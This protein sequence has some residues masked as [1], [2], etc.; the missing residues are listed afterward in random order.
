MKLT[1]IAKIKTASVLEEVK[2]KFYSLWPELL[3]VLKK[4]QVKDGM[5]PEIIKECLENRGY[6]WVWEEIYELQY[7]DYPVC[8][9]INYLE[10]DSE[11]ASQNE[12]LIFTLLLQREYLR[13]L[14]ETYLHQPLPPIRTINRD[15]ALLEG[16]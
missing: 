2:E 12:L 7:L 14:Y 3:E 9:M 4:L 13:Y 6:D 10:M 8:K 11:E 16:Q 15:W 5:T 1:L